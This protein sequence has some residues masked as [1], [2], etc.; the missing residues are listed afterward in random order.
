M[1]V[2]GER[3]GGCVG[4]SVIMCLAMSL[5]MTCDPND[6]CAGEGVSVSVVD[7]V[8]PRLFPF[9][10]RTA[11][12]VSRLEAVTWVVVGG[13]VEGGRT[14]HSRGHLNIIDP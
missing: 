7:F 1:R 6:V 14:T 4:S 10:P 5:R 12:L 2:V 8:T 13:G 3:V 11:T 9:P